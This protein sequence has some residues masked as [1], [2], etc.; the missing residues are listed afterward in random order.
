MLEYLIYIFSDQSFYAQSS[1]CVGK[2]KNDAQLCGLLIKIKV[3]KNGKDGKEN[4]K[5]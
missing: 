2:R 3:I 1:L 5:A 4:F